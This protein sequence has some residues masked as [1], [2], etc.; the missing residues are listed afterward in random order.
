[1]KISKKSKIMSMAVLATLVSVSL[2]GGSPSKAQALS[3]TNIKAGVIS[4]GGSHSMFIESDGTAWI[5]GQNRSGQ[6]GDGTTSVK[7]AP[8]KVKGFSDFITVD[9]DDEYSV[10]IKS[11]GTVWAWGANDVGQLGDGTTIG[12]RTPVKLTSLTGMID[13]KSMY[14]HSVALK[15]DGT[16]WTWGKN[17]NG[18]LGDGTTVDRST[19]VK[20]NGITDVIAIAAGGHHTLALKSDGTVW[21]WGYNRNGQL[22]DGTDVDKFIPLKVSGL[23]NVT[24]ISGIGFS[25]VAL[26]SDGTVWTWGSNSEGD[27]GDGTTIHRYTPVKVSG[28][29][30]VIAID[31][32]NGHTVAL[33]SD[34]TV[35]SWGGNSNK[36]MGNGSTEA[37]S[38]IPVQ[39]SGLNNVVD[40]RAGSFHSLALKADGTVWS[41]GWNSNGQLGDATTTAKSFPVQAIFDETA[42]TITL[43]PS[44]TTPTNQDVTI[45]ANIVDNESG[46][47]VQKYAAGIQDVNYFASGG[48]T[49]KGNSISVSENGTYTVYAKDKAENATI[50]TIA[51]ANIDKTPPNDA[52]LV[53]DITTATNGNVK[54]TITYPSDAVT[55][56][57]KIGA[58]GAWFTYTTPI[59]VTENTTIFARSANVA[60]NMSNESSYV[61]RNIDKIVPTPPSILVSSNQLVITP[62]TDNESGIAITTYQ[63]ND[64]SWQ[65]YIGT[66]K[67]EDGTYTVSAKS[68]DRAGN[69]ST[70]TQKVVLVYAAALA[71]ATRSVERAETN[72]TQENVDSAQILINKLPDVPEKSALQ[73]RLNEVQK[74]IDEK[75]KLAELITDATNKVE[76]AEKSKQQDDVNVA[77]DAVNKLP[78]GQ[79]K[80]DLNHRLD[81]VQ[82]QIDD[83]KAIEEATKKVVIAENSKRQSDVDHAR[84]AVNKLPDGQVKDDLNHRLDEVQKQIDDSI[85]VE[86]ATKKVVTAENSKKQV[87][88]NTAREAVN[89]LPDG[90]AK[91]DLNKRLDEVQKQIDEANKLAELIADATKKV[92]KAEQSK[93]KEDVNIAREAVN[94]LPDGKV[95][96]DLNH[97]LDAIKVNDDETDAVEMAVKKAEK[98]KAQSDV[99]A[100]RDIVNTLPEGSDKDAYH[101]RLDAVDSALKS[102]TNKVDQAENYLRDPYATDAQKLI[103]VLKPSP[104][105]TSLQERL[106]AVKKAMAEK[107]YQDALK[108]AIQKVEQAEK[109]KRDPYISD[110]YD[111][112]NALPNGKDKNDLKDRLDAILSPT[113]PGGDK[114]G[115]FEPGDDAGKVA[116]TIK[117]PIARKIYLDWVKAVERGEKYFSKANIVYALEKMNAVP[118][119]I[120]EN[121]KYKAL[122]NELKVRSENLKLLYNQMVADK[123]LEQDVKNATNAVELYESYRSALFKEKAQAL[124]DSLRDQIAKKIL[125]AR[126]DAVIPK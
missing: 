80:D 94:K 66:M 96:D 64:S 77:R 14:S 91:D 62:G 124:V 102:A 37:Y 110:A 52:I 72:Q 126:I 97:R 32:N 81:E 8:V 123:Q 40:I 26:K 116:D 51:I 78:D 60:G 20:V 15:S 87:D 7:K 1:M 11:D 22:G 106:D 10:G 71:E 83:N 45:T 125:Q 74:K 109:Y 12:K 75:N 18:Q 89:K 39:A 27:L 108:K 86:E 103:D 93:L 73:D 49:L 104:S 35:W 107:A 70:T 16:V 112:V 57:Y 44:T 3:G 25:S 13:V 105:K 23:T 24:K 6:L 9:G 117:D 53:P 118:S 100:A 82:K 88:V 28:L 92:V 59:V 31:S 38:A 29:T 30:N 68:V 55:K 95:K 50:K 121:S 17:S 58:D 76:K 101:K 21:T 67:L 114:D 61:V 54:V 115:Q 85:A 42:P 46:I 5:W 34:G 69:T 36:Q 79:V 84:D 122:Y 56:E 4:A 63:L 99:N 47:S 111:L 65:E 119:D 113:N 98:T 120:R 48:T 33:K 41:W 2:I 19:P 43:V 90:Q